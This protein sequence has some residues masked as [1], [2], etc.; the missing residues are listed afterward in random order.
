[1]VVLTILSNLA[2]F[3][4]S[5]L[6]MSLQPSKLIFIHSGMKFVIVSRVPFMGRSHDMCDVLLY[7]FAYAQSVSLSFYKNEMYPSTA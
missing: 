3:G 2:H 5:P 7:T 1:M 4:I 6:A